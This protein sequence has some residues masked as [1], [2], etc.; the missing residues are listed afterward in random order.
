MAM[1]F[2]R[3][4]KTQAEPQAPAAKASRPASL[5]DQL[6]Q[7]RAA[8]EPTDRSNYRKALI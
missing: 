4:P 7:L 3:R 8:G 5:A 1:R 2:T 6:R